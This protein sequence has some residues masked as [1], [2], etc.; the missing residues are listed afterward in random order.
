MQGPRFIYFFNMVRA[1]NWHVRLRRMPYSKLYWRYPPNAWVSVEVRPS[2][3]CDVEGHEECDVLS[4]VFYTPERGNH[5][6]LDS[7]IVHLFRRSPQVFRASR[8]KL[9]R[10]HERIYHK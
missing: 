6:A 8:N 5:A 1:Q 7:L 4:D 10:T 2:A 9:F 3:T